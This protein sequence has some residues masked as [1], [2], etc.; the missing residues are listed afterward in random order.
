MFLPK[1]HLSEKLTSINPCCVTDKDQK[2]GQVLSGKQ[3]ELVEEQNWKKRS[4]HATWKRVRAWWKRN[5]QQE[6]Q[7]LNHQSWWKKTKCSLEFPTVSMWLYS[8]YRQSTSSKI[9]WVLGAW[10]KGIDGEIL[11][12]QAAADDKRAFSSLKAGQPEES[13]RRQQTLPSRFLKKTSL[14]HNQWSHEPKKQKPIIKYYTSEVTKLKLTFKRLT[15]K[16]S[17]WTLSKILNC[18]LSFTRQNGFFL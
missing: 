9:S 13:L 1:A 3:N 2:N 8:S 6:R 11:E 16:N 15:L 7:Y 10:K 14:W 4:G 5:Q 18:C 17:S 12:K